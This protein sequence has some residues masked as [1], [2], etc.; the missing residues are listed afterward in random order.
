MS[1]SGLSGVT[2]GVLAERVGMSKSRLFAHF[3]SKEEVQVVLLSV[4]RSAVVA[5]NRGR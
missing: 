2:L 3:H 1:Q 4:P 5:T